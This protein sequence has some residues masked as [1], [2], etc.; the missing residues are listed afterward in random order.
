MDERNPQAGASQ[1]L[2]GWLATKGQHEKAIEYFV[3][4]RTIYPRLEASRNHLIIEAE[5]QIRCGR[6]EMARKLNKQLVEQFPEDP[7]AILFSSSASLMDAGLNAEAR[8]EE[9]LKIIN[10]IYRK[11]D[12]APIEKEDP[13]RPLDFYNI[14]GTSAPSI[15]DGPLI[16]V[17]MSVYDAVHTMPT[18]INSL[19]AQTWRNLEIL[20]IDDNSTDHTLDVVYALAKKDSR[21]RVFE[22]ELNEGAYTNRNLGL[23]HAKGEYITVHDADDWSHPQKLEMQVRQLLGAS[24]P[25]AIG[26]HWS[27]VMEDLHFCGTGR[28]SGTRINF[29]HSSLMINTKTL[30]DMGGWDPVRI[31]SDAELIRRIEAMASLDKLHSVCKGV[32]LSFALRTKGSL[33]Q[34]S[35]TH[36]TTL[37]YGVR[38]CYEEA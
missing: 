10:R 36:I 3:R 38:R 29:N 26:S 6:L 15:E 20:V 32:P 12:L 37:Y 34:D 33:T 30:R 2:G 14:R 22:K 27:R 24:P 28:A 11:N 13:S 8:D 21:I 16:S 17:I 18:A 31:A 9:R 35:V 7:D 1:V 23:E 19:L 4:C 5:V 25:I